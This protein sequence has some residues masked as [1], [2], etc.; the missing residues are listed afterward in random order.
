MT[1]RDGDFSSPDTPRGTDGPKSKSHAWYIEEDVHSHY[2]IATLCLRAIQNGI[3]FTVTLL[4][5]LICAANVQYV[6]GYTMND[7]YVYSYT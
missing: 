5:H 7:H 1:A 4:P 3:M 6:D 2:H